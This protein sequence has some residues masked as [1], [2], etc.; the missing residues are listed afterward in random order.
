MSRA[1]TL[2]FT[3]RRC[4]TGMDVQTGPYDFGHPGLFQAEGSPLPASVAYFGVM[5]FQH[6]V[7]PEIHCTDLFSQAVPSTLIISTSWSV[8]SSPGNCG[9]PSTCSAVSQPV[10]YIYQLSGN[11][12]PYVTDG[13]SLPAKQSA[14]DDHL[15]QTTSTSSF[16]STA[17]W[18]R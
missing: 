10:N 15:Y 3:M 6:R 17:P 7:L 2:H 5:L 12:L 13:F 16:S 11:V 4:R 18:R 14:G 8:H 9:C 1:D